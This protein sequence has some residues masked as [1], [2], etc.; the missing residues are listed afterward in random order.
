MTVA[1]YYRLKRGR[2]IPPAPPFFL[3][4]D[5]IIWD[6]LCSHTNCEIFYSSSVENAIGNLIEIELNL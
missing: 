3:K 5:L 1:L 2:L 6:L 4:I